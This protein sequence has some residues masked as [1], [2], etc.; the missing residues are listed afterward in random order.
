MGAFKEMD[1]ER[2]ENRDRILKAVRQVYKAV[3]SMD[4]INPQSRLQ[5]K[6]VT[7]DHRSIKVEYFPVVYDAY[8]GDE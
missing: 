2:T 5:I 8:N 1:I 7:A 4:G 3:E 6:K